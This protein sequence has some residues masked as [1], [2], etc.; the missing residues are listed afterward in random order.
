LQEQ[1]TQSTN[2]DADI[3]IFEEITRMVAPKNVDNLFTI[4]TQGWRA[5]ISTMASIEHSPTP[6]DGEYNS[7]KH[8]QD[9]ALIIDL[10]TNRK[11]L[12][13]IDWQ[14]MPI[15]SLWVISRDE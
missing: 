4:D 12:R 15:V 11:L 13:K 9:Q 5:S 7:D 6:S 14:V 10:E 2:P 8:E 1:T 3:E